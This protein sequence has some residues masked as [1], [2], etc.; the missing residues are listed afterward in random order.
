MLASSYAVAR[1]ALS[2][3]VSGMWDVDGEFFVHVVAVSLVQLVALELVAPVISV[4]KA[5]DPGSSGSGR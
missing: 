4:E 2:R 1:L 3:I 5:D